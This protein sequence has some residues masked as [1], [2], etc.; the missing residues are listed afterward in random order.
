MLTARPQFIKKAL[1]QGAGSK[2]ANSNSELPSPQVFNTLPQTT[3]SQRPPTSNIATQSPMPQAS[4]ATPPA[5]QSPNLQTFITT[6]P[7]T[8]K[9]VVFVDIP[10]FDNTAAADSQTLSFIAEWLVEL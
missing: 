4:P 2:K 8:G 5:S 9:R 6:H 10:G 3:Q 1:E 7:T